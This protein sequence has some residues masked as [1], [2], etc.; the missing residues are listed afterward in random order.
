MEPESPQRALLQQIEVNLKLLLDKLAT[1]QRGARLET[2]AQQEENRRNPAHFRLAEVE[3]IWARAMQLGIP[4]LPKWAG[5]RQTAPEVVYQLQE[6]AACVRAAIAPISPAP[7]RT[8]LVTIPK[9]TVTLSGVPALTPKQYEI[10]EAMLDLKATDP[11]RR[12]T[13]A[14]IAKAA[15]GPQASAETFKRSIADLAHRGLVETKDGRGGG[16]WLTASGRALADDLK[17]R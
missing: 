9:V 13:A 3:P 8:A 16:C 11:A 17:K 15:E 4:G 5:E 14:E 6:L 12:K 10:L 1:G 2:K 7:K